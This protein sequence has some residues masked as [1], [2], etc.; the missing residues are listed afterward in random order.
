MAFRLAEAFV[1]FTVR[2][3]PLVAGLARIDRSVVKTAA[4]LDALSQVTSLS[5]GNLIAVETDSDVPFV[6]VSPRLRVNQS[7]GSRERRLD[8]PDGLFRQGLN[9]ESAFHARLNDIRDLLTSVA[10][11]LRAL[12]SLLERLS[13][14]GGGTKT[15]GT[16]ARS[17]GPNPL[18]HGNATSLP[19]LIS[20]LAERTP[21]A[22]VEDRAHRQRQRQL[23][24][25]LRL[26][27]NVNRILQLQQSGQ[28]AATAVFAAPA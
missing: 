9:G 24:A 3:S 28:D 11:P 22:V 5:P 7:V 4:G 17:N 20:Q 8:A 18:A 16:S 26:D 14:A 23:E 25:L 10:Q 21:A 27:E 2:D 1:E 12:P 19:V 13:T 6:D 15:S